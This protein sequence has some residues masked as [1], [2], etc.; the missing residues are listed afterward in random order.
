MLVHFEDWRLPQFQFFGPAAIH[1]PQRNT[2]NRGFR[3]DFLRSSTGRLL[4]DVSLG[5][6]AHLRSRWLDPPNPP[7]AHLLRRWAGAL[8]NIHSHKTFRLPQKRGCQRSAWLEVI[9]DLTSHRL[10]HRIAP[11]TAPRHR[12]SLDG[13]RQLTGR[14]LCSPTR[15][16]GEWSDRSSERPWCRWRSLVRMAHRVWRHCFACFAFMV[17]FH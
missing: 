7:L 15:I 17:C 8:G 4:L 16:C 5:L 6:L 12:A 11:R 13:A 14:L 1:S 9:A 3:L 10:P 2:V